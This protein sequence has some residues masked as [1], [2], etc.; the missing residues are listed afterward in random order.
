MRGFDG[1]YAF[2]QRA[3]LVKTLHAS[4]ARNAR[5]TAG[6]LSHLYSFLSGA[7]VQVGKGEF[8]GALE[9]GAGGRCGFFEGETTFFVA[10]F[11]QQPDR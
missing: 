9:A 11:T 8:A 1:K 2:D 6:A 10:P 5:H 4:Q 7:S 3:D